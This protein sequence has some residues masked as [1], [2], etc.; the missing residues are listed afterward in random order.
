[1]EPWFVADRPITRAA[2]EWATRR[3]GDQRR[4]VDSAPFIL[5]PLEV[6]AL[7]GGRDYDDEVVAAGLLHDVVE[8]TDATVDDV[9]A[10]FGPRVA[11]IVAA[12]SEDPSI[13]D[14]RARKSALR[15]QVAAAGPEAQAVFAADKVVK[16]RELRGQV[17][18]APRALEDATLRRRLEHY[19][20][21]LD[22]LRAA[23]GESPLVRQLDFELWAL[24]CLPPQS[25]SARAR[26]LSGASSA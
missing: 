4:D 11:A 5:H 3:H 9:V 20:R 19:E 8:N 26:E 13:D 17:A 16:T 24:R 1:M 10:A 7:L 18:V 14:P 2:L 15:S 23:C 6:A 25:G 12:V 21:S 22:M